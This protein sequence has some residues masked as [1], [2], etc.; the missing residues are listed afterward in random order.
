MIH[1]PELDI[2]AKQYESLPMQPMRITA[3]LLNGIVQYDPINLDNLLARAVVMVATEG[4]LIGNSDE[5]YYLPI[6]CQCLWMSPCGLPLWATTVFSP[7]GEHASDTY[8]TTKRAIKG[9]YTHSPSNKFNIK[10]VAGRH[11]ERLLSRPGVVAE[12]WEAYCIGNIEAVTQLLGLI[13]HIGKDRA[14]GFGEVAQ[15]DVEPCEI[16]NILIIDGKLTRP[17]PEDAACA[18]GMSITTPT[19]YLGWSPPQWRAT[20]NGWQAGQQIRE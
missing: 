11:M 4:K 18:L 19:I 9:T 17:V 12:A 15:W 1:I 8:V 20:D 5:P 14:R 16:D 13:T 7:V 3:A 2:L 6:P 10:T